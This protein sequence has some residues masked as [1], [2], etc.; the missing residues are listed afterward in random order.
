MGVIQW[1]SRAFR[2]ERRARKAERERDA[3]RGVAAAAMEKLSD[4]QLLE[5][6]RYLAGQ[7]EGREHD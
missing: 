3:A 7:Q 1:M 5:L 6:R 2:A 4:G